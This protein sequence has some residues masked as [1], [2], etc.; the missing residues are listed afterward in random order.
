MFVSVVLPCRNE[1]ESVG[2]CIKKIK[3]VFKK[4]NIQ[5]EIIISDSSEDGSDNI[6]KS[7]GARVVKHDTPGYGFAIREGVKFAKGDIIIFADADFT[8]NFEDIPKLINALGNADIVMANRLKGIVGKGAMPFSHRFIG[9]PI[10]TFMTNILFG[11][12]VG[13]SQSGFRALRKE[14]FDN[15]NLKTNGMEFASEMIIKAAKKNLRIKEIP[16]N[17]YKRKGESKLSTYNDGMAHIKYILLEANGLIY[18]LIGIIMFLVGLI[19]HIVPLINGTFS[20]ATLKILFPVVGLQILFMGLF[21]KTYLFVR[22]EEKNNF[23][24]NFY[25]IFKLKNA[26]LI[27]LIL[28]LI[29]IIAKIFGNAEMFF[30]TFLLSTIIGIQILFNSIFLSELSIK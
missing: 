24:K 3:D 15:L 4:E 2:F 19:G 14:T 13:D 20:T 11:S 12:K 17:Y 18:F 1:R 7:L 16:S 8:Y 9:T 21:A 23:L 28:I 10:L 30:D 26:L 6:S 22:F 27:G 25:S 5:G 29:P